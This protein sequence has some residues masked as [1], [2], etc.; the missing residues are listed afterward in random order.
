MNNLHDSVMFE[1]Y[2]VVL[3]WTDKAGKAR[4]FTS[5]PLAI[6]E[7]DPYTDLID[8]AEEALYKAHGHQWDTN[9][10]TQEGDT[11]AL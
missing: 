7:T 10:P 4:V 2:K 8:A 3:H 1:R 5:K 11:V 9:I 6:A